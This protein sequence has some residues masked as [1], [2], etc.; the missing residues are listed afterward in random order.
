MA[1]GMG[2]WSM[3]EQTTWNGLTKQNHIS[4]AYGD[5]A[6]LASEVMI[7]LMERR[8]GRSVENYLSKF[9][10]KY[11]EEDSEITWK[12]IGSS[13]KNIPLYEA[14]DLAGEVITSASGMV[15]KN[16]EPFYLVFPENYFA[17][18]NFIVGEKNEI[19]LLRVLGDPKVEG[20]LYV[21]KVEL[22]GGNT[23]GMPAEELLPNK[24]FSDDY[25]AVEKEA[26]RKVGDVRFSAPISM[27]NEFSRI[28][29]QHKVLGSM[30]DK[31]V[32]CGIPVLDDSTG[33]VT[34]TEYWMHHV[35][36]TVE[37][38]FAQDKNYCIV[39]GRSNRTTNGEVR[40]FGKSGNVLETG[41]G[42]RE[43]M[44]YGNVIYYNT[45]SLRLIEDALFEL[46]TGILGLNDRVF[47]LETGE[48]GAALFH[49]AI[50]NEVSGW[51]AFS[52]FGGNGNVN[53]IQK[54]TS[55][56]H[57][58]SL[59]AG[60]QFTEYQAPMGV[61]VKVNINPMNDNPVRNKLLHPDG[62]VA[63]SY[64]FDIYYIGTPDQPNIQIAKVKGDEDI[65]GIVRGLRDPYTGRKGGDMAHD[66]DSATVH[67][68]AALG[69]IVLDPNRTMSLIP[70]ILAA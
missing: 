10:V 12:L 50:L 55:A 58:N 56:M 57:A 23:A 60:F 65:R 16:T 24:R 11:F 69:A 70:A 54:T 26:S 44:E 67:R 14:R 20:T 48:R 38:Q 64:R 37:E 39:Y 53:I 5:N 46:S 33:K 31:K 18:G 6:Q 40:N 17:D 42:I 62:G 25:S 49:K 61:T 19:Y 21:Y 32:K 8:Y 68:Y 2:K 59:S 30:L 43:Q 63:E 52:F 28:R 47:I 4:A 9:P 22:M 51:K 1:V 66:E 35:D 13:K 29:I 27:R 41:A 34:V 15:G 7:R 36:W 45:F 3:R